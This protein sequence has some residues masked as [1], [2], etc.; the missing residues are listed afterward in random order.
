MND[1][2]SKVAAAILSAVFAKVTVPELAT[3]GEVQPEDYCTDADSSPH[4]FP[5]GQVGSRHDVEITLPV[6]AGDVRTA[7]AISANVGEAFEEIFANDAVTVRGHLILEGLI[8]GQSIYLD[9]IASLAFVRFKVR[10]VSIKE[11]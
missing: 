7:A 1:L 4:T 11:Q 9:R 8:V 2:V 3:A 6:S 10:A 5:S